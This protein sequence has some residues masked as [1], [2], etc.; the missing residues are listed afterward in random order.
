LD[1][2]AGRDGVPFLDW[3]L[4]APE[5]IRDRAWAGPFSP[6][7]HIYEQGSGAASSVGW[8]NYQLNA[9][10]THLYRYAD[11][12]LFLAEAEVEG[13]S[14]DRAREVINL[15]RERAGNCA[16]GPDGVAIST[17]IDDAAID[18]ASYKVEQYTAPWTDQAVART[19]VRFERRIELAMEG[20]RLYDLRRWGVAADVLN[21]YVAKEKTRRNYLTS[22]AAFS[23]RHK[24]YPIPIV[25][26][27]LSELEGQQT[28]VQNPG[29]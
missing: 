8:A 20:N 24:L 26:I 21:A 29:W 5:W 1:W 6:K 19:A 11:V 23:D 16:Q 2:T 13:G 25:Q 4:H 10:N 12:L 15:L 27:E 3:G 22:A 9:Q 7:K 28:L 18:W 14:L 17:T